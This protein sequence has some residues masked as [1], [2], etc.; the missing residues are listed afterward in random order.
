LAEFHWIQ[1]QWRFEKRKFFSK[2]YTNISVIWWQ[3]DLLV[4]DIRVPYG[5]IQI[6]IMFIIIQGSH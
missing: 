4:E 6:F 3:S 2:K 5:V 1:I